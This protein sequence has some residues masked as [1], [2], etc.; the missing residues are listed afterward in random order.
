MIKIKIKL[1]INVI[2]YKKAIKHQFP[3]LIEQYRVLK[4]NLAHDAKFGK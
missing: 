4:S 3:N 1:R 2:E